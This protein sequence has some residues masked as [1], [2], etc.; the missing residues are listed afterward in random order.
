M[1]VRDIAACGDVFLMKGHDRVYLDL[2]PSWQGRY[3][4]CHACRRRVW[5]ERRID[6]SHLG[7]SREICHVDGQADRVRKRRARRIAD[8]RQIL[9]ASSRLL[10]RRLADQLAACRIERDL[11]GAE[12]Q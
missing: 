4:D 10:G 11:P 8:G 2:G 3:T 7:K 6:L 1:H 5:K 9:Q 12:Q